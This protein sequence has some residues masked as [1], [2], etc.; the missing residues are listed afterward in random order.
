MMGFFFMCII[1]GLFSICWRP[2]ACYNGLAECRGMPL[3]TRQEQ[4]A[5]EEPSRSEERVAE[6]KRREALARKRKARSLPT[7]TVSAPGG[8]SDYESGE[9]NCCSIC[10]ET[11]LP[12]TAVPLLRCGHEFHS[13]CLQ[14]WAASPCGGHPECA[15]ECAIC[16]VPLWPGEEEEVDEAGGTHFKPE[17]RGQREMRREENGQQGPRTIDT[18]H[19][20]V[21]PDPG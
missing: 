14:N 7:R 18:T 12:G 3:M 21:V 19:D 2:I 11:L 13:H 17:Q 20:A 6:K 4:V 8:G 16:R 5:P 1:A 10:L 9:T 15:P